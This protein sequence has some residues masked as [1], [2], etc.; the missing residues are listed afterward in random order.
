MAGSAGVA[1]SVA[2]WL[3]GSL[4]D[5][6]LKFGFLGVRYV[7]EALALSGGIEA[8]LRALL[9]VDFPSFGFALYHEYEP[10]S[11][12]WETWDCPTHRQ[13]LDESSRSHHYQASINTFLR[14]HVAGLD[15]PAGAAAWGAV[16]VRPY[17]ALPLPSDLE[18][19]LPHARATLRAHRGVI[20]VSWARAGA[21]ASGA[22]ELNVTL[23]SGSSGG[24]VSVPKAGAVSEGGRAVWAGGAFVPGVPGVLAGV[25]EEQWLTF[26]VTSG[27]F[28][29]QAS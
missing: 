6:G 17:A 12:L 3:G 29:F 25:E 7:Y 5:S 28:Q 19:A 9:R 4:V 22:F 21:S 11:N 23:P 15:M 13:W 26:S 10:T 14:K 24:S 27:A 20:E 8:A 16:A 1:A 18:R 2:A